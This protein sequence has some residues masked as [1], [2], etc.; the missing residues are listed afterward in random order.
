MTATGEWAI[1]TSGLGR[2]FGGRW[3]VQD[4]DLRVP[5]G[6]VLGFLGLNGAGKTTTMRMLMGL[7]TPHAGSAH[8]LGLDPRRDPLAVKRAVGFVGEKTTYYDWMTVGEVLALV[9]HYRRGAWDEAF[10]AHL[11][12]V[13]DL[14]PNQRIKTLSKGQVAKV[15]LL[16]AL[17]FRP[18]LL[19]LDEPT[20]GLDPVVRRE[21]LERLLAEYLDEGRTIMISSHLVNE[22]AGLVDHVG[23]IKDGRLVRCESLAGFSTSIKSVHLTFTGDPPPKVQFPGVLRRRIEGRTMRLTIEGFDPERTPALLRELGAEHVAIEEL[24]LENMFVEVVT[25][26]VEEA[27]R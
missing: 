5:R 27:V 4:L 11:V 17:A 2:R 21:F 7:L 6:S 15:G 8:V 16:L 12:R 22:I 9:A 25:R 20:G 26:D 18:E 3:V 24:N 13:F 23:I 10:A 1:E 19:I 14:A